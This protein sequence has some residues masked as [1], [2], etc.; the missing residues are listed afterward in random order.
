MIKGKAEVAF[1]TGDIRTTT[2]LFGEVGVYVLDNQLPHKI[3]E[4]Q[5][6]EDNFTFANKDVMLTFSKVESVDVVIN[7]L[8]EIKRLMT[9]GGAGGKELNTK[10]A[11]FWS[12]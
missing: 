11:D 3:G 7:G 4:Q 8:I 5:P 1:G 2:A 10:P 12:E 9:E 6:I